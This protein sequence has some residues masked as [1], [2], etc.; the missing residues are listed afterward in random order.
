MRSF[1]VLITLALTFS[2]C[3]GTVAPSVDPLAGAYLAVSAESAVPIAER[4]TAAFAARHPGMTW[5][6]KDVGSSAALELV[7]GGDADVGFLSREPTVADLQRA[8]VIGL[9][10]AGQVIIVHP[11]NPVIGLSREQLRGIFAGTTTDW[12]KVGGTPGPILV[13]VRPESSPTRTALDPLVRAPGAGYGPAAVSTPD[14]VSMLN[15]VAAS[16]RAIG[17]ISAL[18]LGGAPGTP[19]PI[20][21]DGVAPTRANVS[22][23]TYPYRRAITLIFPA[24]SS[25]IRPGADAFRE[26]VH[27]GNGQQILREIF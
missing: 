14:A 25:R 20:A 24:N 5:T 12:S 17:M 8:Q 22:S 19:R 9:G 21:V 27:G 4:L 11:A 15:A 7:T 2:G 10:Y 16:P 26:F 6:V 23:G 1:A 13:L 3:G 18:H